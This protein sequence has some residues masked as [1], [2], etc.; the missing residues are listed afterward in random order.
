VRSGASKSTTDRE[1]DPAASFE[2]LS[3]PWLAA[4]TA[5]LRASDEFRGAAGGAELVLAHVVTG[6]AAGDVCYLVRIDHGDATM[7]L[8]APSDAG[9][10]VTTDYPTA[11]EMA[12]GELNMQ[13]AYMGGR[14]QVDGDL[15]MLLA[16]QAAVAVLD[17][18]RDRVPTRY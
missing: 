13:N 18:L 3:E 8:G 7:S 4:L 14:L 6:A 2:F 15:G 10:V 9:V 1:P 5:V 11:V 16:N 12:R 17:S